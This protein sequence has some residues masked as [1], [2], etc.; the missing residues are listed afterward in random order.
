VVTLTLPLARRQHIGS[1]TY[2][3]RPKLTTPSAYG[4]DPAAERT[5][6]LPP[7]GG[8]DAGADSRWEIHHLRLTVTGLGRSAWALPAVLS[9]P[10]A[11]AAVT[12]KTH[13]RM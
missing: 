1:I 10:A 2:S 7:E 3:T 4:A 5:C 13:Q 11:V 12:A 9:M 6:L 8:R